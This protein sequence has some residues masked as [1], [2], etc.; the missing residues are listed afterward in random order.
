M[1]A[2]LAQIL[3]GRAS[4]FVET[5][6]LSILEELSERFLHAINYEG[7]NNISAMAVRKS[8]LTHLQTSPMLMGKK[9]PV[10]IP[11]WPFGG[12]WV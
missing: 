12:C 9:F 1:G 5:I 6:E 7:Q 4:T 10:K 2:G 3:L 11:D 8:M